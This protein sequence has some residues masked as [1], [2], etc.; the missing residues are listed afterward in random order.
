M[1]APWYV[2]NEVIHRDLNIK[3]VQ[4]EVKCF[5]DKYQERLKKHSNILV[6]KLLETRKQNRRL[7]RFQP[8]DLSNRF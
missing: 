7:K 3:T 2:P 1:Q 5:S 8:L 6:T 4:S